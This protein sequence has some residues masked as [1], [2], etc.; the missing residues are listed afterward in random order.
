MAVLWYVKGS[1][2][3][4]GDCVRCCLLGNC[5]T[6]FKVDTHVRDMT[7]IHLSRK[8]SRMHAHNE[9]T[10]CGMGTNTRASR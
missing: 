4:D 10:T 7:D 9:L 3:D 2:T 5:L 1:R 8:L 6:N